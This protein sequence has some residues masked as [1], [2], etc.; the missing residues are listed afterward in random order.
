MARLTN[1]VI[2][3]VV[4]AAWVGSIFLIEEITGD[5][6]EQALLALGFSALAGLMAGRWWVLLVPV[7]L[8]LV[9]VGLNV[10]DPCDDCR[11]EISAVGAIA[12]LTIYIGL[13]DFGLAAGVA[14]RKS[15][16]LLAPSD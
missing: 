13:A 12:I 6:N 10:F 16:G 4:M 14:L 11:N 15:I 9:V 3:G 8:A 7:A 2:P 5:G 1:W